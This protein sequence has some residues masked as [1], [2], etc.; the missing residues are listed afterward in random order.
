VSRPKRKPLRQQKANYSSELRI[1]IPV[2]AFF[3]LMGCLAYWASRRAAREHPAQPLRIAVLSSLADSP[4]FATAQKQFERNMPE[5]KIEASGGDG[6]TLRAKVTA[7]NPPDLI[8]GVTAEQAA[9]FVQSVAS[10]DDFFD[11]RTKRA[12]F[13]KAF[14]D[15]GTSGKTLA[16]MPVLGDG[17]FLLTRPRWLADAGV[18]AP[19]ETWT[20]LAVA[21]TKLTQGRGESTSRYGMAVDWGEGNAALTWASALQVRGAA[22]DPATASFKTPAALDAL[23]FWSDLVTGG[24]CSKDIFAG[25]GAA[26]QAFLDGKAAMLWTMASSRQQAIARLTAEQVA[27]VALPGSEAHGTAVVTYGA[28]IPKTSKQRDVAERFVREQLL[29]EPFQRAL[30]QSTFRL[31]TLRRNY[32]KLNGGDW[33]MILRVLQRSRAARPRDPARLDRVLA[34]DLTPAI[35]GATPPT[36]A[37]ALAAKD[38]A[39]AAR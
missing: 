32:Q 35:T 22:L 13:L 26:R 36:E 19:F 29:G 14:L 10:W 28:V 33:Q 34:Q 23:R 16:M 11:P 12:D 27:C 31:P 39:A 5:Y 25:P 30:A 1:I 15:D 2:L 21:A 3:I 37:L 24:L 7:K 9:G 4:A 38:M 17:V 6:P 8:V 18:S 20:Q